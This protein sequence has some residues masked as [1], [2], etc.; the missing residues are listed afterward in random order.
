MSDCYQSPMPSPTPPTPTPESGATMTAQARNPT[1]TDKPSKPPKATYRV[2]VWCHHC[3]QP[4][5]FKLDPPHWACTTCQFVEL[6]WEGELAPSP[7][8]EGEG[9]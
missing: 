2:N 9:E 7:W 5:V 4:R 1:D 6:D 8:G 3:G